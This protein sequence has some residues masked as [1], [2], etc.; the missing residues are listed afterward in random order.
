MSQDQTKQ[1]RSNPDP[2][3]K[4]NPVTWQERAENKKND[5]FTVVDH[6]LSA[7]VIRF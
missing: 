4:P 3:D 6:S 7:K 5:W 1:E 2:K